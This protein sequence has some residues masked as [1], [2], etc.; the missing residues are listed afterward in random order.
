MKTEIKLAGVLSLLMVAGCAHHERQ[1]VRYD[2]TT[3]SA[4]YSATP[5]TSVN[6]T[7]A[8]VDADQKS[9]PTANETVAA[10]DAAAETKTT[11][12]ETAAAVDAAQ[13]NVSPAD[14]AVSATT[15]DPTVLQVRQALRNNPNLTEVVPNIQVSGTGG[16]IVLTGTVPNEQQK[17]AV[18]TAVRSTTGVVSVNNQLEVNLSPTGK[19]PDQSNRIYHENKELSPTS[20]SSENRRYPAGQSNLSSSSAGAIDA[21]IQARSE[22]DRAI[23]QRIVTE[24]QSDSAVAGTIPMVQISVDNGKAT[25]TGTVDTQEEKRM[26]E[27]DVHNVAGVTSVKNK[28][29][30]AGGAPVVETP[31]QKLQERFQQNVFSL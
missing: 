15:S 6:E 27:A 23:G 2:D 18:E 5:K 14:T 29:R 20:N 19:R 7:I 10:V 24:L 21:N 3:S 30:V 22:T 16:A 26:I 13:K 28:L 25:L 9:K 12:N 11:A 17:Q 1:Q 8:A 4:A 31:A